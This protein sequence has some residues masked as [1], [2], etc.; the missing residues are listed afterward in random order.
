MK[1][2]RSR[3]HRKAARKRHPDI[4][5]LQTEP[6]EERIALS[7]ST[8]SMMQTPLVAG[9]V[10]DLPFRSELVDWQ[11]QE[12]LAASGRWIVSFDEPTGS[13]AS[14][15]ALQ[16]LAAAGLSNQFEVVSNLGTAGLYLFDTTAT[17]PA[18]DVYAA[19]QG[20]A[21]FRY[22][23]PD[24]IVSIAATP[25]DPSFGQ[26][27]GLNNTGQV[28]NG[29]PGTPDADIDAA[30]AWDTGTG[31]SN[32][33]IGIIDTGIDYTH[34]DLVNNIW[35]NPGEIPSNGIDDDANGFID[36]VHG[37]D[38]LNLDGDPM[39]DHSHG[40]HTA[41]TV[42]A[43]GN[44][45]I[46][47][48]GVNWDVSLMALKFLGASG[49]GP[50]SAAVAAV[51]YVSMMSDRGVN[52]RATNN[53]W[54]GGGFDAAMYDAIA[55]NRDR[56]ILFVA[57]AGNFSNNNDINPFYPA[58]YDLDNLIAVAATDNDDNLAGFSHYGL[59]TVDLGAPG[60]NTL[61]TVPGGYAY[62][63][64]TSMA[65]PHVTGAVALAFAEQPNAT[66]A[67]VRNA[68]LSG[69]DTL[70][71]LTGL[72]ATGGRLN[73]VGM[74]NELG[75]RV[76][77]TT[78][79]SGSVLTVP[80]TE[81]VVDFTD[82][83]DPASVQA[84]DFIV[85]GITADSFVLTDADTLTFHFNSTPVTTQGPQTMAITAGSILRASDADP[86]DAFSAI[87][88]YDILPL[89]V[90]S[91]VPPFPGG[92]FT[93]PGPVTLD[94]T[95]NE[96]FDPSS[97]QSSDLVLGGIAGAFASAVTV[98]PGDT[99]ARFTIDGLTTT[100]GSL[101]A[102]IAA[103]ALKDTFGSPGAAFSTTYQ[104][105]IGTVPY[106]TPLAP[107]NPPGS[108]IYDP[109]VGGSISFAG[110][111]DSFT[112]AIDAGQTITVVVT[113]LIGNLQPSIE[114]HDP[115]NTLIGSATAGAVTQT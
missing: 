96:P 52:I 48:A 97:V 92:I 39:D 80:P 20:L 27:Y 17:L 36:D 34:P 31:S 108:L 40:T 63:D 68:I 38:F 109:S 105:D 82:S 23:E 7:V 50:I 57:A 100:E 85:N 37:Y 113:P 14:Q 83:Y 98:L 24:F 77:S 15:T 64:G 106:P 59:T 21:G 1:A 62:F 54:G 107:K 30:E 19:L 6:L 18:Q 12:R 93:L 76:D 3:A 81:F 32:V 71:S 25:N 110:D 111:V 4:F 41:G 84:T 112:L 89:E 47:V 26:L 78:P 70:P 5:R 90:I 16:V 95:F 65:T 60:V 102:S 2:T 56:D 91:T 104:V 53:S 86:I 11:G 13:R 46:G 45:G 49:S 79:S 10:A 74:L 61:S 103:G 44:N 9:D 73:L 114:L 58:S 51:N 8:L 69:V 88:F 94:V 115:A 22:A 28:V 55:D 33:V 101:T 43:E 66:Y 67:D 35:T 72:V 42:G 87:F 99:T 75:L 29:D